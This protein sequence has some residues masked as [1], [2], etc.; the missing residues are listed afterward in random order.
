MK[1]FRLL[2]AAVTA[3]LAVSAAFAADPTGTWKWTQPSR[4]DRPASERT[5][6]L[7]LKEG[8]LSG[9]LLGFQGGQFQLPDTAIADASFQ[10][11]TV[12]FSVT[13]EFNGN[14][15]TTKYTGKLEGDS[16]KGTSEAPGRDGTVM[17]RDWVATRAK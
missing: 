5:L 15:R 8:R 7:E 1:T 3:L 13:Y 9:T 12:S 2:L 6:K 16:I 10:D 17:K 4:G 11:D 14:Q